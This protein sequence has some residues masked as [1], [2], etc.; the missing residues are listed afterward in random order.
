MIGI[1]STDAVTSSWAVI[2][3]QP[4]PSM[5]HT[6]RSGRPTLAPMA[7][8]IEK[9]IVPR[10][11]ELTHV[12]GSVNFQYCDDHIWCWPTPDVRIVP[13]GARVAQLL[14]AELRLRARRPGSLCS[15]VS[16]NCSRQ[17]EMRLRHAD[18]SACV[19]AAGEQVLDRPDDLAGDVL[20][21]ADDRHV[22]PA[23][24]ALLGRVDVDVD[25]LGLRGEAVDLAGDAVVEAGAEGD[26]QVAALH[27][28]DR[29][30]V[31]VH[32]GHARAPA[33]GR[34]GTHHGPSAS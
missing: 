3:K 12:Y 26:Q 16:G 17:P 8:G 7:A 9:P 22:G 1:R 2:W 15:Y 28:R 13:S 10:P 5:A 14:E 27:R 21:V 33:G 30:G 31:A 29:R 18:V 4:S 25:D 19:G 6:V 23:H 11:P 20:A 24:L 34:R 32:A